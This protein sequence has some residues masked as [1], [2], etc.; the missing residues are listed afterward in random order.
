MFRYRLFILVYCLV[1]FTFSLHSKGAS[2]F[3]VKE[4]VVGNEVQILSVEKVD[5][6]PDWLDIS[7]E[8]Q[9][10]FDESVNK[11]HLKN[12]SS[13]QRNQFLARLGLSDRKVD[14][15]NKT[16]LEFFSAPRN[17]KPRQVLREIPYY[18]EGYP[19][20]SSEIYRETVISE[21][22]LSRAQRKSYIQRLRNASLQDVEEEVTFDSSTSEMRILVE[23]G[24]LKNRINLTILGD[25]YMLS[26]KE[27]F[28]ADAVKATD[29]LFAGKAFS[30]YLPL[31]NVYAVFTA[32]NESGIGDGTPKQ[33]AFRLYRT[34]KGS[35]RAIMPGN[36]GALERALKLAPA[37]D[38]PVVIA[39]DEYY[40]GLGGRYAISTSSI[41]S[42]MTVLRHELGHNF[43]EVG[44]EY[45]NGQVYSGANASPHADV[46]WK[47]WL[48][49]P[50]E[51][52]EAKLLSGDYVWMNLQKK[53]YEVTFTI[54]DQHEQIFFE[55]SSV[56]WNTSKD[57]EAFLN[58]DIFDIPG[59]F[60]EDRSFHSI[61]PLKT[62]AGK[63]YRLK[64]EEK[65]KDQNNVLGFAVIFSAPNTY[66][67]TEDKIGAFAS[68]DVNGR[69][70]YRPTHKSCL[71]RDMEIE[72]FC[73]VD[74]ENMW[75][76][77]LRRIRL[78]DGVL[79]SADTS[80]NKTVALAAQKL[81]GL[82]VRWYLVQNG[83]ERE[84]V[85]LRD[86]LQWVAPPELKGTMRVKTQFQTPEVRK[87]LEGYSDSFDFQLL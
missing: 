59:V 22:D 81:S 24:P 49:G 63:T 47:H 13:K 85:E 68:Y 36:Q 42:G 18:I 83:Q 9:N 76:K 64:I 25:G 7:G 3:L 31:F 33:T 1:N 67:F 71:M 16:G 28:F 79:I 77:F 11:V 37:T 17:L 5:L 10:L 48:S 65:I 66:D 46:P 26:E 44:E 86:V 60:H 21:H 34:P 55:L 69:K 2:E 72:K 62:E 27:K 39:N 82:A 19:G 75:N 29:G 84:I 74:R 50:L 51:V 4:K 6:R 58:G 32:S 40:G 70:F 8:N 38:Y 53:P 78:I 43:G 14:F 52:H 87:P 35:K 80:M 45:D 54:P 73:V 61:G 41:A 15:S 30:S 56:G 12:L 57:V 20:T 23:Q